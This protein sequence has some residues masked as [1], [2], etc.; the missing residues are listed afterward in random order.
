M[1]NWES[2]KGK[3]DELMA[4]WKAIFHEDPV[5]KGFAT[6]GIFSP[7]WFENEGERVLF[8]LKEP[9]VKSG[10][11]CEWNHCGWFLSGNNGNIINRFAEW[12]YG[13]QRTKK[14]FQP[15]YDNWLGTDSVADYNKIRENLLS[16]CALIN[17]KKIGN[18]TSST[19][20]LIGYTT[21]AKALIKEQIEL[22][23]P[24][25]IICGA[26]YELLRIVYPELPE[27]KNRYNEGYLL[28]GWKVISTY[29]PIYSGVSAK[30]KF[31][32]IIT[33][34]HSLL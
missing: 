22:I 27:G 7:R 12:M 10:I 6:D 34:Y 2:Y 9:Y 28:N 19:S 29:H 33:T 26:T 17:L 31:E 11:P 25:V 30:R 21:S 1:K 20:D 13:I 18:P 8:L 4:R 24:S 32:N 16:Q 3:H 14:Y 23:N 5:T 15:T